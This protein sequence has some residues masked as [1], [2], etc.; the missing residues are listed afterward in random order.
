MQLFRVS[1][2]Y[3][4][5]DELCAELENIPRKQVESLKY[6]FSRFNHICFRFRTNDKPS[7]QE[8]YEWCLYL[9]CLFNEQYQLINNDHV[10]IYDLPHEMHVFQ[11][12]SS[13]VVFEPR[14]DFI[15]SDDVTKTI[16]HRPMLW[17]YATHSISNKEQEDVP[18]GAESN[19]E[20]VI[21]PSSPMHDVKIS[22]IIPIACEDSNVL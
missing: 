17:F 3:Y 22:I 14:F 18:K 16:V 10:I 20:V 11:D 15:E 6:L 13:K 9:P 2:Q 7:G 12:T 8:V 21:P 5:Y 4:D 1:H 19:L